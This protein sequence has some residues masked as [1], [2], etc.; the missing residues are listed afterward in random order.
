MPTEQRHH[1]NRCN[2][3]YSATVGT[4]LHQTHLPLQ[5]WL[6]ALVLALGANAGLSARQLAR[7][8]DVS[9]DTA[10]RVSTKIRGAMAD[11]AQRELLMRLIEIDASPIQADMG[12]AV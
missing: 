1:C 9:K 12:A 7:Q 2:T 5:K 11:R 10:L 6:L 3:S 8:L 4:I